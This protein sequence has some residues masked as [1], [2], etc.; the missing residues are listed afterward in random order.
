MKFSTVAT[1]ASLRL[2]GPLAPPSWG[3]RLA[4]PSFM[5]VARPVPVSR[6][7]EATMWRARRSHLRVRGVDGAG[8][9]VVTYEWGDGDRTV[10]LIHGW[11]GRASQFATLARELVAEGYRVVAFDAPAHGASSGRHTY[12]HDWTDTMLSLQRDRGGFEMVVGHSFGA[13]AAGAATAAGLETRG[14]VTIAGPAGPDTLFMQFQRL[15]GYSPRITPALRR[16]FAARYF[17]GQADPFPRLSVEHAALPP[18]TAVLVIHDEDDRMM[19]FGEAERIVA[20]HPAAR[21]LRTRGLGHNRILRDDILL[22]A[23]IGFG[24]SLPRRMPVP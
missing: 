16:R 15:A 2:M 24:A 12:I 10:V 20:A 11:N 18:G 7:D 13:L 6:D 3:A 17:P 1:V 21:M 5:A 22:D 19:P 23:V 9:E 14:L 8:A 4:L